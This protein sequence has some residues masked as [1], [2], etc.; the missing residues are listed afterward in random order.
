[1]QIRTGSGDCLT[2]NLSNFRNATELAGGG[3]ERGESAV[4]R[5][6]SARNR[7]ICSPV[8]TPETQAGCRS[9]A[10]SLTDC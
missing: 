10:I 5:A 8:E 7:L 3:I 2:V 9:P 6:K 1:M 4:H